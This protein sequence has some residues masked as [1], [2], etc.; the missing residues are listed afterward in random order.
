MPA[1]G[2]KVIASPAIER[3]A[4]ASTPTSYVKTPSFGSPT[5]PSSRLRAQPSD[6]VSANRE[7]MT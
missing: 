4:R 1:N 2:V 5:E 6:V 3:G 7:S